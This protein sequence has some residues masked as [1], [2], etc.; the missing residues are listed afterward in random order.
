MAVPE[1]VVPASTSSLVKQ[2]S[3]TVPPPITTMEVPQAPLLQNHLHRCMLS[4]LSITRTIIIKPPKLR[5][6]PSLPTTSATPEGWDL[7]MPAQLL[8]LG[9]LPSS[10]NH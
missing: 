2:L 9:E 5:S 10:H 7:R 3:Q 6:S 8:R 4:T 1:T